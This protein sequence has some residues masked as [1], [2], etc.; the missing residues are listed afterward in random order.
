MER[1]TLKNG[2]K[3]IIKRNNNTPRTA[4]VLCAKLNKDEEK[5]GLY[6]LMVQMLFQGTKT[7]TSEYLVNELEENGIDLNIEKKSDYIRFKLNCLNEDINLALEIM[8]D[9]I[10]NSTFNDFEKEINKIKGEFTADLDSAK[11]KAQD[12]YY[13]TIFPNHNYGIGRKEMLEQMDSIAREDLISAYEDF[14]QNMQKNIT[15]VG[16][17]DKEIVIPLLENHFNGLNVSELPDERKLVEPLT[18]NIVSIIEKEDANQAQIF[19][20]WRVPSI[21]DE[22]YPVLSLINTIMGASGL[23]SRLFLELREKRGLAYTVRSVNEVFLTAGHFFVYIGTEP[24]NIQVSID[25]FKREMDKIMNEP[26]SDEELENAKNN[27]IGKRQFYYQTNMI[28]AMTSGYYEAFGL[29]YDFEEKL[30]NS[31]KSVTKEKIMKVSSK[32]FS[33]S[34]ALCVLA[35]KKYLEDAGLLK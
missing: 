15:V 24:K 25:G 14:K 21:F 30:I 11:V 5:T 19:Q 7:R 26:I 4:L 6:Y 2:I 31:I 10:E 16:D 33:K 8:Q 12:E 28:E 9:I 20:G 35:P 17:L 22:D 23:S 1:Y 18:D 13:R 27:A 32:Y 3:S 29:G 34:S